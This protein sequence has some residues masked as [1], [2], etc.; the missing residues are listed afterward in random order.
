MAAAPA[1]SAVSNPTLTPL[2]L[3]LA[4]QPP[5]SCMPGVNLPPAVLANGLLSVP[6]SPPPSSPL[7]ATNIMY[8]WGRNAPD[9]SLPEGV[10]F[11]VGARTGIRYIVAQVH[12]LT[13]QRPKDDHSGVTLVLKPQA[14]PYSAGVMAF[15]TGFVIPP[16]TPSY[17]VDN[18]CCYRGHQPLTTFAVRVHTHALG[19]SVYMTRDKWD[20][21]GEHGGQGGLGGGAGGKK[22]E[23]GDDTGG[24]RIVG[25]EGERMVV[26]WCGSRRGRGGGKT[27][28]AVACN[29]RVSSP[30]TPWHPL[31]TSFPFTPS[32]LPPAGHEEL[33]CGDPQLPQAHQPLHQL[34]TCTLPPPTSPSASF[35]L[36][37]SLPFPP[38][39]LF[40][41]L[42]GR[43][44]L[45]RVKKMWP[46][47]LPLHAEVR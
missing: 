20:H 2:F 11:S 28:R 38:V 4:P 25:G 46:P 45:A 30:P 15:A 1:G 14:V 47:P 34:S 42:A 26:S 37:C 35:L 32:P 27:H 40:A 39:P 21:S 9:L 13:K 41:A 18:E 19:R 23:G 16:Q 17:L 3:S 12:Y 22:G 31:C 7:A 8:G 36:T 6:A 24:D 29:K 33:A 10:G 43:E 44:E 5:A